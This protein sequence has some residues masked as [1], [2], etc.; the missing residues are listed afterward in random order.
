MNLNL[1]Q[2]ESNQQIN[3]NLVYKGAVDEVTAKLG[4]PIQWFRNEIGQFLF[5][6]NP[7][8]KW[9]HFQDGLN[10]SITLRFHGIWHKNS[11]SSIPGQWISWSCEKT[12]PGWSCHK[13]P[14]SW[15]VANCPS[16]H[17]WLLH[18]SELGGGVA[19]GKIGHRVVHTIS[20]NTWEYHWNLAGIWW[21]LRE[22][23]GN[24]MGIPE[25]LD[26]I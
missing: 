8:C 15:G 26:W 3:N 2:T 23:R 11:L 6:S 5:L 13:V 1:S 21:E 10:W 18:L 25:Y 22:Y 20:H 17:R 14:N 19:T 9:K 7:C 24:I 16:W 12:G 4:L